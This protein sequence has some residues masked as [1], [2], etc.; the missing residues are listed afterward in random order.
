MASMKPATRDLH[1]PEGA[2]NLNNNTSVTE[3]RV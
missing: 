3:A 1:C 2:G